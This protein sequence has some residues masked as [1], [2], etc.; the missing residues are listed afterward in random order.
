MTRLLNLGSRALFGASLLAASAG[1]AHAQYTC[2]GKAGPDVIVGELTGPQ[3]YTGTTGLDALS[4]G[5]TSCN[6]GTAVLMWDALPANTHP[7]IGGHLYKWK[8]V[9]GA[10]RFEQ[11][12]LSW[13][14]HGFTALQGTTCC[15]CIANPNGTRLGVGCSDPYTA[16][17]NGGQT[18]MGPRWQVNAHTGFYPAATPVRPTGGN[19]GR[20]EVLTTDLEPSSTTIKYFGE[21]QYV[22]PDDASSGNQNNNASYIGISVTGGPTEFNFAFAGNTQRAISAIRAWPLQES[23]VTL[24]DVQAPGDGLYVVGSKATDLGGGIWHY[25]YAIYNMNGDRNGGSF[26]IP[27]PASATVTNIGFHGVTYRGGDGNG[28]VNFSNTAWTSSF[29][30]G[31]VTWNTETQAANNNANAIRWGTTYNFRFDA[32]IAPSAGTATLGLWKS[33]SPASVDA[34]AQIP[35]C[36]TSAAIS[37]QPNPTTVCTSGTAQFSIAASGASLAYAWQRESSPGVFV[38]L[39]NGPTSPWD[40]GYS[41]VAATVSGATTANLSIAANPGSSLFST[42]AVNYRC[43]VSG[44]CGGPVTSSAAQLSL[45]MADYNCTGGISVQ[46]LFDYLAGWFASDSR[47]D[48]NHDGS[49]TVSDIFSFIGSWF[50]G[51]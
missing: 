39:A 2:G 35:G 9:N 8:A 29:S 1:I 12:G 21:S 48:Y 34:A 13:L 16:S 28:G 38:D 4:L 42:Q 30:G 5:T 50:T 49:A 32:N 44:A 43:R 10:G 17:R 45:C 18:G 37:S 31:F 11:I 24:T 27:V 22:T 46:D 33:G 47:A 19:T 41:G 25:E 26:S 40:G 51:C 6:V 7:V 20:L 14:K 23:G 15:T 3:N 36:G